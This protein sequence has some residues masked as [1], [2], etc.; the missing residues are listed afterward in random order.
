MTLPTPRTQF[1][2]SV[3]STQ[4]SVLLLAL[5]TAVPVF[6]QTAADGDSARILYQSRL[7]H[8]R[9]S[10][11]SGLATSRQE[12]GVLWTL[13]DSG[14]PP[15]LFATDTSGQDRGVFLVA[16]AENQ[17]WEALGL[18]SCG[19]KQCLY[20]A[21]TGDNRLRRETV[22]VYRVP[23]PPIRNTTA[24]EVRADGVLELGFED[25]PRNVEAI[26]V[27]SRQDLYLI[28]KEQ[29]GPARVYRIDGGAWNQDVRQTAR[30]VQ[31]LPLGEGLGN[32]VT[33]ASL[34]ENGTDLAVR[35]YRYI[36]FFTLKD[37]RLVP[38]PRRPRCD[39]PG[40]DAQGEAITWLPDGRLV[41]SS[42]RL[43]TKGG[44]VSIIECR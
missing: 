15:E 38:D 8:P 37:G 10:E 40:L 39:A 44:T 29:R 22:R 13:N 28:S 25:G 11:S 1:R 43:L 23:E 35:T 27:T 9:L 6:G 12:P 17:D 18:A 16:D 2:H 7:E 3:L 20:A 31:E 14:N 33:D 36:F 26:F 4:Y 42:E 30:L 21:D 19:V 24:R 41:T 32:Q 34:A 5:V